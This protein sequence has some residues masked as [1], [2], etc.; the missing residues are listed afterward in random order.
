[1]AD[2]LLTG[3]VPLQR[4]ILCVRIVPSLLAACLGCQRARLLRIAWLWTE[5]LT[6][7]AQKGTTVTGTEG[8]RRVT[9]TLSGKVGLSRYE[10]G[11]LEGCAVT[12]VALSMQ[13]PLCIEC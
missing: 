13:L 10:D 6:V 12:T 1:M 2:T 7:S 8:A 11:K 5:A 4:L 9:A 3:L